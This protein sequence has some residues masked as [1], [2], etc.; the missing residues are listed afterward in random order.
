MRVDSCLPSRFL[1]AQIK[2]AS[3]ALCHQSNQSCMRRRQAARL[4]PLV[5]PSYLKVRRVA[6]DDAAPA[7]DARGSGMAAQFLQRPREDGGSERRGGT[8]GVGTIGRPERLRWNDREGL[9]QHVSH[10]PASAR[11]RAKALKKLIPGD[12]PDFWRR[13]STDRRWGID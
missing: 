1:R 4:R 12:T 5:P 3:L 13:S 11:S 10:P 8:T 2:I 7:G 9:L 6:V